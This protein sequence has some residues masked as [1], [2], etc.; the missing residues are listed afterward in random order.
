MKILYLSV[1]EILEFDEVKLL[2]ELGYEIFS[3]GAYVDL[4]NRG[5][6]CLR[7]QIPGLAYDP[8]ILEQ[9]HR[10]GAQHPGEDGKLYL[11]KDFVDNFDCVLVMHWPDYV[12]RNWEV[13][14][15]KRVIWRTIGQSINK[16]E[17]EMRPYKHQGMQIVRY[18][19]METTIPGFIG[20]DAL[21]R[22]YKDPDEFKGWTGEKKSVITFAQGMKVRG[23]ACN[24]D[25]FEE[26]TRPF[27]RTLFGP[28][29]G[30]VDWSG[31]KL[32]YEQMK[33]EL[34]SNR[35]YFYTGT[36]PASYTLNFVEA[37]MTGIPVV[38][39]GPGHGNASYFKG[40]KLYEIHKLIDNGI[41]GFCS[42]DIGELREYIQ[43]LF[44]S[45]LLAQ[46]IGGAGRTTAIKHF[47]KSIIKAAWRNFLG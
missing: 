41:S 15:H 31:G 20:M 39:V 25:F 45:D 16:N 38:A 17:K 13:I 42:D 26:V 35:V 21:I 23:A 14:K 5:D 40:H 28:Q 18:S 34:R 29:N 6:H 36:H 1:H 27:D 9:Y 37:W 7:P 12:R 8:D 46:Q 19:P 24:F 44:N 2:N 43:N 11:T 47:G 3:P 22:F 30:D 32:S 33:E 4:G 10:I